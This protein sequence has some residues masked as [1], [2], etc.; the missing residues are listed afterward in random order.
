MKK[1]MMFA[2]FLKAHE[3]VKRKEA[4]LKKA[5]GLLLRLGMNIYN[6]YGDNPHKIGEHTIVFLANGEFIIG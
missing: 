5:E 1:E 3:E 4:E 6:T 2:S